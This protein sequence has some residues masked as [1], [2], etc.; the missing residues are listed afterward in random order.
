MLKVKKG[1]KGS[2]CFF[3]REP[4]V[5]FKSYLKVLCIEA[6]TS[7]G[8]L[9]KFDDLQENLIK[10]ALG[11]RLQLILSPVIWFLLSGSQGG[12]PLVVYYR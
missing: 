5:I 8:S 11:S 6:S 7:L 9:Q 3:S 10:G 2:N 1:T 4:N 12:Y